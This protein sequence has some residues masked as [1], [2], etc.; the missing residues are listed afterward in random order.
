MGRQPF[1]AFGDLH[2]ISRYP[3]QPVTCCNVVFMVGTFGQFRSPPYQIRR[4]CHDMS[5]WIDARFRNAA[6]RENGFN[7]R[8]FRAEVFGNQGTKAREPS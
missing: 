2:I 4:V 8:M 6:T 3:E 1:F 5:P 7:G